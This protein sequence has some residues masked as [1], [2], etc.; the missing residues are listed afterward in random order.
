MIRLHRAA[1]AAALLIPLSLAGCGTK[2]DLY[3]PAPDQGP[4]D[5]AQHE[6]EPDAR[7]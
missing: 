2:G 3:L 7:D 4:Q 6:P 1:L 5:Q